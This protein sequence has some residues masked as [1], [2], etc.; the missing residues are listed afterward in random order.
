MNPYKEFPHRPTFAEMPA[1]GLPFPP[2]MFRVAA[3]TVSALAAVGAL[4]LTG[5]GNSSDT[6]TPATAATSSVAAPTRGANAGGGETTCKDFVAADTAAKNTIIENYL[7]ATGQDT[8]RANVTSTKLSAE[9][10]CRTSGRNK[11]VRD[12]TTG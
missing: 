6:A 11:L 5:C 4:T 7:R 1:F 2:K 8:S 12:I 3:L 10:F 9:A